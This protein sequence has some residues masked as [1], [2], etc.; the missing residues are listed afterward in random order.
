MP[1]TTPAADALTTAHRFDRDPSCRTAIERSNA[2][3]WVELCNAAAF[4]HPLCNGGAQ[5]FVQG[6]SFVNGVSVH[7]VHNQKAASSTLGMGFGALFNVSM[8]RHSLGMRQ[9]VT[10]EHRNS[11]IFTFV[12]DPAATALGGYL[13]LRHRVHL[14]NI[15]L[16]ATPFT[17]KRHQR[18]VLVASPQSP[19]YVQ[20]YKEMAQR[21]QTVYNLSAGGVDACK[22]RRDATRQFA[23]F[24]DSIAA[25]RPLGFE[26]FHVFPQV[27]KIGHV[28]LDESSESTRYDAIG[29][30]ETMQ[31]DLARMRAL[32]GGQPQEPAASS[33]PAAAPL[34]ASVPIGRQKLNHSHSTASCADVDLSDPEVLRRLC[35]LYEADYTCFRYQG[36]GAMVYRD[37]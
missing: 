33:P 25:R 31:Q 14:S 13:E 28:R 20:P 1:S 4:D 18:N 22:S 32:I 17:H 2:S 16:A 3:S 23:T 21:W 8:L 19:M 26:A 6:H 24:L 35:E 11:L 7:Y 29:R 10:R 37:K 15:G 9:F 27:F 34:A 5:H 36:C 12:R 30:V